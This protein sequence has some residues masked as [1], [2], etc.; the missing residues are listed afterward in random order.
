MGS[1]VNI[2]LVDLKSIVTSSNVARA[3]FPQG[4][5]TSIPVYPH[6]FVCGGLLPFIPLLVVSALSSSLHLVVH[7]ASTCGSEVEFTKMRSISN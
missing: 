5:G 7:H 4:F 1:N 6:S 3:P 2:P